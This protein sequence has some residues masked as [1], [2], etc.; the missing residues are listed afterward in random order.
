MLNA[1]LYLFAV[2][3]VIGLPYWFVVYVL[4]RPKEKGAMKKLLGLSQPIKWRHLGIFSL[5]VVGYVTG[6]IIF[7]SLA[8][9]L[10]GY[11]PDQEQDVG[12]KNLNGSLDLILAFIALVILP[13][14]AEELVF[15]GYL[16]GK[17]RE[18]S[19]FWVS[20]IITSIIFGLVHL[21][22]N[23]GVDT[24]VLSIFLCYLREKTGSIWMSMLLHALKNGVAYFFLF[25]A[26][27]LGINL[28]Q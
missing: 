2:I 22:W 6:T 20:A 14:I 5:C 9:L 16:F 1:M 15:R 17:L 4:R 24:F 13:P 23:V 11:N 12:F 28:L 26:P 18:Q 25:I 21:Q 10:P 7:S 27:L 3:I 8:T 19:G